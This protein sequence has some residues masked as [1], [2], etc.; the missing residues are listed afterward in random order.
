M[1]IK[2]LSRALKPR[3]SFSLS[4]IVIASVF[5]LRLLGIFEPLELLLLDTF[6]KLRPRELVESRVVIVTI[7]EADLQELRQW[8]ISDERLATLLKNLNAQN[9]RVIALDI[10]RD[11]GIEPG[12]EEL[13]EIF[14]SS[15]NLIGIKQ[16]GETPIAPPEELA[17]RNRVGF[18]NL[19]LDADGKVRRALLAV[20]QDDEL[21]YGLATF[22]ALEYLQ[23]DGIIPIHRISN[24]DVVKLNDTVFSRL[25]QFAGGYGIFNTLGYQILL[26][27]RKPAG[28][29]Q[30][31]SIIDVL[32]NRIPTDLVRD[33]IVFIGVTAPSLNDTFLTPYK[34]SNLSTNSRS[35]GVEIHAQIASQILSAVLDDRPLLKPMSILV[36]G[37]LIIG[38]T[39]TSS[40]LVVVLLKPHQSR[41]S[42]IIKNVFSALVVIGGVATVASYGAFLLG[43]WVP[44]MSLIAAVVSTT[45]LGTTWQSQVLHR[46]AYLDEL[47]QI[48]NRRCF[49]SYIEDQLSSEINLSVVLCD[50]DYF[51]NFNDTYGHQRGDDCLAQVAQGLRKAI[52]P[53]DFAARYGG[54]EFIV[55]LPHTNSEVALQITERM[56]RTIKSL[57]IPNQTSDVSDFVTL[58]FGVVN[59]YDSGLET[60]EKLIEAADKAL[61]EAKKIGRDRACCFDPSFD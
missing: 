58:S 1:Q 11:F 43:W 48:P 17:R 27:Y 32:E 52:R 29:F 23:H 14:S 25:T 42:S 45:A 41:H 39:L 60:S 47:T 2:L 36:E 19:L 22:S 28:T 37:L 12:S 31:L 15:P 33:R 38:A 9:P 53:S 56:R 55:L 57:E 10:Y 61:Y 7:D 51:K 13:L 35:A 21:L 6:F 20:N 24:Q 4:L 5:G 54:E 46:L 50:I 34:G 8:P 40:T 3:P 49:N 26:N 16:V 18:S 59:R 44:V 30:S